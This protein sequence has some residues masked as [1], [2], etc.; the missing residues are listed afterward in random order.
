MR[1]TLI[2]TVR[3]T[4]MISVI[5]SICLSSGCARLS[6]D[7]HHS[8]GEIHDFLGHD[9]WDYYHS[10]ETGQI[11]PKHHQ[12]CPVGEPAFYG[13]HGTCWRKWPHGWVPCPIIEEEIVEVIEE[14]PVIPPP[15]AVDPAELIDDPAPPPAPTGMLVP[16]GNRSV[17]IPPTKNHVPPAAEKPPTPRVEAKQT[18]NRT[19]QPMASASPSKNRSGGTNE[20]PQA[21]KSPLPVRSISEPIQVNTASQQ[22]SATQHAAIAAKDY[23][24]VRAARA[25]AS[26]K[27]ARRMAGSQESKSKDSKFAIA[28]LEDKLTAAIRRV[29]SI[30]P[31]E[32]KPQDQAS[33]ST[34]QE[35]TED[36]S[37]SQTRIA[38]QGPH[39]ALAARSRPESA[40]RVAKQLSTGKS[41]TLNP[42]VLQ[43]MERGGAR[44]RSN[45]HQQAKVPAVELANLL[46]RSP[47]QRGTSSPMVPSPQVSKANLFRPSNGKTERDA[48]QAKRTPANA[49]QLDD[50]LSSDS[51]LEEQSTAE[52]VNTRPQPPSQH[53][54]REVV[55]LADKPPTV[56]RRSVDSKRPIVKFV[57]H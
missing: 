35:R 3:R 23:E 26:P 49:N 45:S 21:S 16:P 18:G 42:L 8:F 19:A 34:A 25:P 22:S 1:E 24:P 17:L 12:I 46:G 27:P 54:P 5:A 48:R 20:T 32:S 9:G 14:V 44:S 37:L 6:Y 52:T 28:S 39:I 13:Y 30:R 41:D 50:L 7:L 2:T 43:A 55:R 29:H 56:P 15:T 53:Q 57:D 47:S 51:P 33:M 11:V 40:P 31:F 36:S 38:P 4:L 10:P